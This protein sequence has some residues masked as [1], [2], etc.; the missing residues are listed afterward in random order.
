MK[1]VSIKPL[2]R[3]LLVPAGVVVYTCTGVSPVGTDMKITFI[4]PLL[5]LLLVPAGV[6]VWT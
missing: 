3:L 2:F 4:K 6:V 5:R 1:I